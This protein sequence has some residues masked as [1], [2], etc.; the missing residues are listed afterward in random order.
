MT[1]FD[2]SIRSFLTSAASDSSTPGGGSVAALV[3]ALGASMTSMVANLTQ[4]AKFAEVA[5][6][7]TDAAA[8]MK[9]L[10]AE[11]ETLLEQD[12]ASFDRY[13]SALK[14]PKETDEQK[15]A[16]SAALQEATVQATIVPRDLARACHQVLTL[17]LQIAE[18]A[19]KNVISDLGIAALLAEAAGQSAILT[20]DINL[21]GIKNAEV[22]EAF[23][24]DREFLLAENARL[25]DEII[26]VVRRRLA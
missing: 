20:M 6:E 16:R 12:M 7:M 26:A 10:I 11:A 5:A 1:T 2:Q 14:L 17:S 22:K 13:M 8:Q 3:A 15:V 24:N 25:K 21:P 18:K 19:N 23:L 9:A 4:G